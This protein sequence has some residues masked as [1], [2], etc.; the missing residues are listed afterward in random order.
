[1]SRHVIV[2]A[3]IV[4]CL[5]ATSLNAAPLRIYAVGDIAQCDGPAR[6]SPAYKTSQMI[7]DD[8]TVLTLG[9]S[10]YPLAT[11]K[12]FDSCYT[13][14]WGRHLERTIAV[15]GNHDYVNGSLASFAKYFGV[16]S[17]PRG[18]FMRRVGKWLLIGLDSNQR[19]PLLQQQLNWLHRTLDEQ[20]QDSHCILAFWH[21]ALFSSGLHSGDGDHMRQA[22]QHLQAHGA[23]IVL[24]GHE[25]FY[26]DFPP[27]D[28][29][30]RRDSDGIREFVVGTG[31]ARLVGLYRPAARSSV[32]RADYGVLALDVDDDGYAWEF[33]T[34][35]NEVVDRG[36]ATCHP[37]H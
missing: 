36:H 5:L 34:I 28:D 10:V 32:R 27:L 13:P 14:T 4:A 8:A 18:Y 19:G 1:M 33:K 31:G 2:C 21:H 35:D 7:P 37:K 6:E 17:D 20:A 29:R 24:A 3:A 11:K 12:H 26:E 25:H 16:H 23:D 30:G 22:W 9:D 15:P